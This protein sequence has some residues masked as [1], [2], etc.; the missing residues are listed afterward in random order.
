MVEVKRYMQEKP[1]AADGRR[2][3]SKAEIL[4]VTGMWPQDYR[5]FME[6]VQANEH[7]EPVGKWWRLPL[8]LG[9]TIAM[10]SLSAPPVQP[11]A[12]TMY[13]DTVL[14]QIRVYDGAQWL[15]VAVGVDLA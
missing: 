2:Y 13:Y 9:G 4:Q 5:D 3:I 7:L 6:Y 12:G 10:G 8:G 15:G 14:K 1:T 11:V